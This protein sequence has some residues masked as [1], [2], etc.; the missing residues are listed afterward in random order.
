VCVLVCSYSDKNGE[1]V[2]ME[3]SDLSIDVRSFRGAV[4]VVKVKKRP[5]M[6]K[7]NLL[8]AEGQSS[9]PGG[10]PGP[11]GGNIWDTLS[12]WG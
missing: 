10:N 11:M 7:V 4:V 3:G 8:A 12:R 1:M 2:E 5:G 6:E 9:G